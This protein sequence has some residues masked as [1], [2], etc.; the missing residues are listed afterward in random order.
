MRSRSRDRTRRT[1]GP[2]ASLGSLE[3]HDH[4]WCGGAIPSDAH[5]DRR[6]ARAGWRETYAHLAPAETLARLSVTQRELRWNEILSRAEASIWVATERRQR[7]R[8]RRVGPEPRRRRPAGSGA[9][10][11]YVLASHH[12]TGAGQSLLDAAIGDAAACL[13]VADDNPARACLLH[14]QRLRARW[15]HEGGCGRGN[16]RARGS[17]CAL[18]HL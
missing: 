11:I 12:G 4:S 17:T 3:G 8:L 13:W 18:A 7:R 15:C 1:V 5:G 9:Q 6:G 10:S 16:P 2:F 14:A